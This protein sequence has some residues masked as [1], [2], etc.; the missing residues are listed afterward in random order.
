MPIIST[1]L[2]LRISTDDN[3]KETRK[4]VVG[5][6]SHVCC[7]VAWQQIL[8]LGHKDLLTTKTTSYSPLTVT[9]VYLS[10]LCFS[11]IDLYWMWSF[12]W[13]LAWKIKPGL[14]DPVSWIFWCS[15]GWVSGWLVEGEGCQYHLGVAAVAPSA[16]LLI[17]KYSI[18]IAS[19]AVIFKEL[20]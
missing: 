3:L 19:W 13:I 17:P 1:A 8:I 11:V 4:I 16:Y 6:K 18:L 2:H 5:Q 10:G 14:D 20:G 15:I 9:A 12:S 7:P